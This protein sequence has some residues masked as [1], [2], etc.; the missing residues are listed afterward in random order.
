M[1]SP[2]STALF[3][4]DGPWTEE[5]YLALPDGRG[6]E[7]LDGS[8]LVS[9]LASRLHQWL[10]TQLWYAL[11][12]AAPGDMQVLASIN[13]RVAPGR[14]FGP[15][16]A[17]VTNPGV[18]DLVTDATD[19]ALVVEITSPSNVATDRTVKPQFYAH[20]GIPH[21]LRVEL[22]RGIPTAL[23]FE[24]QGG[25]YAEA[26]RYAPGRTTVLSRPFPV[27]FDLNKLACATRP[28]AD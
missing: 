18:A 9:P 16:L 19:V 25:R 8:L 7:L 24:L 21:Y 22:N 23:V 20:A 12:A 13:V 2:A 6:I 14:I 17:V 27:S 4:H 3:E 11:S 15:D 5:D 10:C 26:A 1:A 28:G